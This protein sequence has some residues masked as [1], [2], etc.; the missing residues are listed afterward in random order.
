MTWV[1]LLLTDPS[2]NLRLLVLRE[3]LNRPNNDNEVQ[4]LFN[5]R[6]LTLH[7]YYEEVK[8][9][10]GFKR[11]LT[12][13]LRWFLRKFFIRKSEYYKKYK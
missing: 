1:P 6:N 9:W 8:R 11:H 12:P 10:I 7:D 13:L 5:F 4:E 3:L 2:P